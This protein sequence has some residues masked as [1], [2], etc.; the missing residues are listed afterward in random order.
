MRLRYCALRAVAVGCGRH[1]LLERNR[2]GRR[3]SILE[4][5]VEQELLMAAHGRRTILGVP[6]PAFRLGGHADSPTVQ[7]L[8]P[9]IFSERICFILYSRNLAATFFRN[10]KRAW[11]SSPRQHIDIARELSSRQRG[12]CVSAPGCWGEGC[13]NCRARLD[14]RAC[15][16]EDSTTAPVQAQ[17]ALGSRLRRDR[18]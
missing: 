10:G 8:L 3:K 9:V 13:A 16:V 15:R 4:G 7:R 18:A 6:R 17:G 12:F 5:F 11:L 14:F 1:R 2:I